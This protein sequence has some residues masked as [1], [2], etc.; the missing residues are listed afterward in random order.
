[1]IE[2]L[3]LGEK[4]PGYL[5]DMSKQYC[6]S[7]LWEPS[8][9]SDQ[10]ASQR[11][12]PVRAVPVWAAY[13]DGGSSDIE[14]DDEDDEAPFP[15]KPKPKSKPKPKPL[16]SPSGFPSFELPLSETGEVTPT[17]VLKF[18][19]IGKYG[20]DSF[21]MFSTRLKG[22]GAPSRE[23]DW[24]DEGTRWERLRKGDVVFGEDK[25]DVWR[26][27]RPFDKELIRYMV[28]IARFRQEM[29]M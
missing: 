10:F 27:I 24:I 7:V 26:E 6:G 29:M 12:V 21:G 9:Q 8:P 2:H 17:S 18:M 15:I 22:G 23:V 3:G 11:P 25:G 13:G 14:P 16:I 5:I 28:G 1:M 4:R 19:G 20:S